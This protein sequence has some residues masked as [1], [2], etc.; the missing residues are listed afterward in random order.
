MNY[1]AALLVKRSAKQLNYYIRHGHESSSNSLNPNDTIEYFKVEP[2]E[3]Q[4]K[5]NEHA[6]AKATS[7][8]IEMLGVF[9]HKDISIYFS[10]DEVVQTLRGDYLI[11]HKWLDESTEVEKWFFIQSVIQTAFL[12]SLSIYCKDLR[13]AGFVDESKP[14]FNISLGDRL[15][16]R[17]HFGNARY[18]VKFDPVQVIRFF[19]TKARCAKDYRLARRFDETYKFREWDAYFKNHIKYRKLQ[20]RK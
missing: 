7:P 17:L 14:R 15:F 11:E 18:D 12:G 3:R 9:N 6:E 5:G 20:E 13:T 8:Y 1:S 10:I 19:L 4:I 2:S 16:S